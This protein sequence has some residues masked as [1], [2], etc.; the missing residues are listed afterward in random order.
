MRS[1]SAC[2][3]CGAIAVIDAASRKRIADIPLKG[4][5][6]SFQL[7]PAGSQIFVNV[8]DAGQIAIVSRDANEQTGSWPTGELRA[9]FPL[10]LDTQRSRVLA[11]FRHPARLQA[12]DMSS[13]RKLSGSDVCT[14]S[15]DVFVNSRRQ[16]VYVVCGEGY[17]D[18]LD[19]S[20]DTFTRV[21][22]IATS[23]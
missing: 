15:D 21:G 18:V 2:S 11:V 3:S 14:D 22:H 12:Y 10:G 9:N 8:P 6:E 23:A 20:A 16:R 4:H 13:G 19:S 7:E 17:V 1:R 5:P